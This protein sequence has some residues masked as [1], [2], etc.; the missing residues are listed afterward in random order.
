MSKISLGVL[1][2]FA[3]SCAQVLLIICAIHIYFKL[4]GSHLNVTTVEVACP[5]IHSPSIPPTGTAKIK[6]WGSVI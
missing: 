5:A 1:A 3:W 2:S 4:T 6:K